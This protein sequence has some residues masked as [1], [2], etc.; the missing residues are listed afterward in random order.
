MEPACYLSAM[1]TAKAGSGH[2]QKGVRRAFLLE[3]TREW[4]T[5]ELLAWT[6][7]RGAGRPSVLSV[8]H[9]HRHRGIGIRLDVQRAKGHKA[10]PEKRHERDQHQRPAQQTEGNQATQHG[11]SIGSAIDSA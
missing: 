11:A 10:Q 8:R 1:G 6:H 2:V 5:R 9:G 3:P 7:P 4:T